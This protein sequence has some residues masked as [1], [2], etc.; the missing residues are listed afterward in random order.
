MPKHSIMEL[1]LA[2]YFRR[3]GY[4]V[5]DSP[6]KA[7]YRIVGKTEVVFVKPLTFK[8]TVIGWKYTGSS[9]VRVEDRDGKQLETFEIPDLPRVNASSEESAVLDWRRVVAKEQYDNLFT[10]GK[11]FTDKE[12]VALIKSLAIDPLVAESPLSGDEVVVRLADMGLRAVPYLLE[13]L[14]DTRIVLAD[15]S[16]PG[17]QNPEDLKIYH[18]ADKVLEE[19]FQKV[20]RLD[21]RTADRH[22]F[23]IIQGWTN[24]WCRFC[25]PLRD[26]PSRRP[27][28]APGTR[29]LPP[30]L[31][32]GRQR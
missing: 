22:R 10:R 23:I 7:A 29:K 18:I 32:P 3:A 30:G 28:K 21:L 24:E 12:V 9:E 11:V 19:I 14:T 16:Y 13:A 5:V 26:S 8:G 6:G 2:E 31:S 17:L 27:P 15:A 1:Y 25:S 4:A 20:S